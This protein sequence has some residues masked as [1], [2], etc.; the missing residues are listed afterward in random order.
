MIIIKFLAFIRACRAIEPFI[1]VASYLAMFTAT[2]SSVDPTFQGGVFIHNMEIIMIIGSKEIWII[3]RG[4]QGTN[5]IFR[6]N[7]DGRWDQIWGI[8]GSLMQTR[9]GEVLSSM[10]MGGRFIYRL[11]Q[12]AIKG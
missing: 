9:G 8:L 6:G 3:R 10:L 11:P 2:V 5:R 7:I 4:G 12:S 1:F